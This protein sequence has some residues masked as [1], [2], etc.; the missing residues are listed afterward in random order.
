MNPRMVDVLI[1]IPLIPAFPV[2]IMMWLPGVPWERWIRKRISK[3][4]LGP[5]LLYCSFA[6]WHFG[7]Q[8]WEIFLVAAAGIV[9]SA[10]AV[11]DVLK[12]KRLKRAHDWPAVEASFVHVQ[13][14]RDDDGGK[15][16]LTYPYKVQDKR[17]AGSQLFIFTE[18]KDAARFK[19]RCKEHVLRVHYRPDKPDASA[20]DLE[21]TP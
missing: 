2:I 4:I 18:D 17:Y 12:A 16:T 5:Y 6:T 10:M 8:W 1:Y 3:S 20:L 19:D 14:T 9:V 7:G 13:E 15:V 11:F 21:G